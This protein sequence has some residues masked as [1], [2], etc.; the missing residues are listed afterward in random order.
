MD[1]YPLELG[2]ISFNLLSWFDAQYT[3]VNKAKG[4]LSIV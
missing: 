4:I 2:Q 3:L 1:S